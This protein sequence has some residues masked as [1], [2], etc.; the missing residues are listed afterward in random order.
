VRIGG[1]PPDAA[2]SEAP[3]ARAWICWSSFDLD[4]GAGPTLLTFGMN[5]VSARL[6]WDGANGFGVVFGDGTT[7]RYA[8]VRM[9]P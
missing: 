7:I 1:A 6:A 3:T 8:H 4:I 9:C 5:V 2:S